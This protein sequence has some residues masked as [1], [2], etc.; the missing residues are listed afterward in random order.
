MKS[1]EKNRPTDS[2]IALHPGYIY[3]TMTRQPPRHDFACAR[4]PSGEKARV[5]A[6]FYRTRTKAS[7]VPLP[8]PLTSVLEPEMKPVNRPLALIFP[9]WL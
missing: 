9:E 6:E 4:A 7:L 5:S 2:R 1:G 8:S 3:W